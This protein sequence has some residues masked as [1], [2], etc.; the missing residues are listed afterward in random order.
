MSTALDGRG[1]TGTKA[2][3]IASGRKLQ[4]Q[5]ANRRTQSGRTRRLCFVPICILPACRTHNS[6]ASRPKRRRSPDVR[7]LDFQPRWSLLEI[8]HRLVFLLRL[9]WTLVGVVIAISLTTFFLMFFWPTPAIVCGLL[10]LGLVAWK[11]VRIA[12][13]IFALSI[14]RSKVFSALPIERCC[15]LM[16]LITLTGGSYSKPVLFH[17]SMLRSSTTM[18]LR[19]LESRGECC[20]EEH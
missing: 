4:S 20:S 2:M 13:E 8:D 11:M 10:A 7:R 19:L 15:H 14:L 9:G 18:K 17:E 16:S 5:T 12:I 6:R 3:E 1:V